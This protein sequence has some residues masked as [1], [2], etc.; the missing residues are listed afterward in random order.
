MDNI[1]TRIWVY[2][3]CIEGSK[4]ESAAASVNNDLV[5]LNE[6]RAENKKYKEQIKNLKIIDERMKKISKIKSCNEN[7]R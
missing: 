4:I 1:S 3:T 6:I 2:E 5:R 7:R